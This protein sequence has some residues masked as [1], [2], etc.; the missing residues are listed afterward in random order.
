MIGFIVI[1]NWSL[2]NTCPWALS[3]SLVPKPTLEIPVSIFVFALYALRVCGFGPRM[4]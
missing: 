1:V 3:L 2:Y 4:K